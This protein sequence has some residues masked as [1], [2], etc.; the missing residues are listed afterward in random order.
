MEKHIFSFNLFKNE[1]FFKVSKTNDDFNYLA[2]SVEQLFSKPHLDIS[3]S[4]NP[5][6]CDVTKAENFDKKCFILSKKNQK[7]P[8][9]HFRFSRSKSP[10]KG[11][12]K[13]IICFVKKISWSLSLVM[14][15]KEI[16]D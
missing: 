2:K 14:F 10:V 5:L 15:K 12:S 13:T 3:K 6:F 11:L 16:T 8:F 1:D 9:E 4:A 7:S